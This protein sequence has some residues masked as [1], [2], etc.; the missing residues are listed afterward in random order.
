MFVEFYFDPELAQ[1]F[2]LNGT[3]GLAGFPNGEAQKAGGGG[4]GW[5]WPVAV[6]QAAPT[7]LR[8]WLARLLGRNLL[9]P[10]VEQEQWCR[11]D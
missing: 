9:E 2:G 11:R 1:G 4:G 7:D 10:R 3:L 6:R 8:A 5:G